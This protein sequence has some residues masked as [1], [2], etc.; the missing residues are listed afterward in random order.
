MRE[1]DAV[2]D[3]VDSLPETGKVLSLSTV[4]AVVKNLLGEDIGCVELAWCRRACP[5]T[6]RA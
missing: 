2:H 6:S 4:F 5:M 1:L 3:Y